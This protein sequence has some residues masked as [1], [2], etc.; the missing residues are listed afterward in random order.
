MVAGKDNE[1]SGESDDDQQ[2]QSSLFVN[3]L[4]KKN[5]G[6]ADESEEWSDDDDDV[7][8]KKGKKDKKKDKSI[9]GKRKRKDSIDD[10]QDF[11]KDTGIE[12]VPANDP[13]TLAANND[14][15]EFITLVG[16]SW[17]MLHRKISTESHN[18]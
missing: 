5:K 10:V 11:F 3:P 15:Y 18:K 1:S 6:K 13:G 17:H 9:L 12:E 16:H 14:G 7:K 8:D 2:Q 4:A